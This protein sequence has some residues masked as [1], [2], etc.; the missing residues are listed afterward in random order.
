M[1]LIKNKTEISFQFSFKQGVSLADIEKL[2]LEVKALNPNYC[3]K[4]IDYLRQLEFFPTTKKYPN[5]YCYRIK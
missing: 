5:E 4:T 2:L 3:E 1:L